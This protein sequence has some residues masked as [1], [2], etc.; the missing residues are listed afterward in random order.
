LHLDFSVTLLIPIWRPY[1]LII[2]RKSQDTLLWDLRQTCSASGR[3]GA[4]P[5]HMPS[6]LP[7][8]HKRKHEFDM[9]R[10]NES[11]KSGIAWF[12]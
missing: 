10:L 2:F 5:R 1:T 9:N 6:L 7:V 3:V 8:T 12:S 4:V 11:Q